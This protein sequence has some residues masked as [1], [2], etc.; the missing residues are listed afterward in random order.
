MRNLG[1]I[2]LTVLLSCQ[3]IWAAAANRP[4]PTGPVTRSLSREA[5]RLAV[6]PNEAINGWPAVRGIDPGTS[7]VVTTAASTLTRTFV[8]ADDDSMTVLNG[9]V[10]GLSEAQK[11]RL[12][13]L[14]RDNPRALAKAADGYPQ[15]IDE[16]GFQADGVFLKHVRLAGLDELIVRLPIGDVLAVT[17]GSVR[18]GS[19]GAA[20]LGTLGGIWLGSAVA[21]GLAEK[22][23]CHPGC[24]GVQVAMLSAMIGIPIAGGYYGWYATSHVT[25]EVIYRRPS[26]T[27]P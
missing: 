1:A 10:Q 23:R 2:G 25:E 15:T 19:A 20:V 18:R 9:N 4:V 16:F 11:W 13:G 27:S 3:P 22:T 14:I 8:A 5:L 21:F 12:I 26:G 17:T 24:G 6:D 7:I